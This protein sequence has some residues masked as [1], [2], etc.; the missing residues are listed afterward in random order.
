MSWCVIVF[1]EACWH[2]ED[3]RKVESFV[4]NGT[5]LGLPQE[6]KTMTNNEILTSFCTIT[7]RNDDTL[8]HGL[9]PKCLRLK[10]LESCNCCCALL[11]KHF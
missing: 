3:F 6:K 2:G 4:L 5:M 9:Y 10:L 8:K 11:E 1:R 7:E